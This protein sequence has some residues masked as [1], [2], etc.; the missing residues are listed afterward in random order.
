VFGAIPG[1][2]VLGDLSLQT[3]IANQLNLV[4]QGAAGSLQFWNGSQTTP[5]GSIGGGSGTWTGH[6]LDQLHRHHQR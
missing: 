3:A 4:V 2:V 5:N 1:S 6:Q